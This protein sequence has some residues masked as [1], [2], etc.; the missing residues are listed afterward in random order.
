VGVPPCSVP[1]ATLVA[2]DSSVDPKRKETPHATYDGCNRWSPCGRD[3]ASASAAPGWV[4]PA[5]PSTH[6]NI[7]DRR[8]GRHC[9][10]SEFGGYHLDGG[11]MIK[12]A[13][14]YGKSFADPIK[15]V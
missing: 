8:Y 2:R 5:M 14:G 9:D 1:A 11:G 12:L 10:A 3:P 15:L 7:I 6:G 13:G 4:L